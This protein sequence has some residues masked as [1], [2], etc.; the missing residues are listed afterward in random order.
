MKM[1]MIAMVV[2]GLVLTIFAFKI[3]PHTD[4]CDS[5][6]ASHATRGLL[7]LGVAIL[8]IASTYLA[9]GCGNSSS[10]SSKYSNMTLV[11]VMMLLGIVVIVLTSVI[12]SECHNARKDTPFLLT[13]ASLTTALA[14]AYLIY[15]GYYHQRNANPAMGYSF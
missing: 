4:K 12:H 5:K 3:A 6:K 14:L 13:T 15:S 9:C 1:F 8:T 10:E 11:V 7:V 2:V